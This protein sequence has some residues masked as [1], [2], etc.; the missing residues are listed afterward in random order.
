MK[1]NKRVPH[2]FLPIFTQCEWAKPLQKI[3][4]IFTQCKWG[5]GSPQG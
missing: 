3:L 5:G 4:P 2:Q 1:A